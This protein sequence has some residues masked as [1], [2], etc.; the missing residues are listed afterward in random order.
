VVKKLAEAG[1]ESKPPQH[2]FGDCG[3]LLMMYDDEKMAERGG[4][5]ER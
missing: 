3:V 2:V 4:A 1:S 5:H